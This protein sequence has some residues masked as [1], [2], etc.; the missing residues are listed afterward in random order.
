MSDQLE[1]VLQHRYIYVPRSQT[2][3]TIELGKPLGMAVARGTAL[4]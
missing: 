3:D 2:K 1:G 4:A